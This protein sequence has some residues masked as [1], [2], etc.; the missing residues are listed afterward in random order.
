[1][2]RPSIALVVVLLSASLLLG[3]CGGSGRLSKSAYRSRL[4]L[5]SKQA[6]AAHGALDKMVGSAKTVVQVQEALRRFATAEDRLGNEL[7]GLK[8]PKDAE[9]VNAKLARR[10]RDAAAEARAAIPKLSKFESLQQAFGF[11]QGLVNGFTWR[12][13]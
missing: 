8:A 13:N 9:S 2:I 10:E 4:A 12:Y 5:V 1:V 6:L 11:L 3:S 7:A